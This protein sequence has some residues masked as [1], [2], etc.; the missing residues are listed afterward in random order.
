MYRKCIKRLFDICIGIAGL[1]PLAISFLVIA[2][3]IYCTDRGSI[4]YNAG[5]IGKGGRIF[6]MYK[7]RTMKMNAPDIRLADGSTYN[8]EDDPRVTRVGRVLRRTSMDELPQLINVLNGTMSLIGPRP[9]TEDC[10]GKYPEDVKIFLSVRPGITGY[11]QAFFRN[12]ADAAEKM[13]NDAYYAVHY[14][15]R[16]DLKIFLKTISTV[17][18][19][20]NVYRDTSDEDEAMKKVHEF[21]GR[22]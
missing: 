13:K 4:F 11:N 3:A 9:D 12:H 5:R 1:I 16:M 17:L 19:R 22:Q 21:M 20:E 6:K 7:Y 10:L 2:P 15:F 14:S 18:K 8:G